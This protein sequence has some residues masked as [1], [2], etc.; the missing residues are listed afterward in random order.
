MPR[1]KGQLCGDVLNSI[2]GQLCDDVTALESLVKP[3]LSELIKAQ[4][5]E[6]SNAMEFLNNAPSMQMAAAEKFNQPK[7]LINLNKSSSTSRASPKT[8]INLNLSRCEVHSF[9]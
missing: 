1:D 8:M 2:Q 9:V 4:N 3:L 6:Q 5:I 7:A